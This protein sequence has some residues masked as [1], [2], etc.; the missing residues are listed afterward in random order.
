MRA[1]GSYDPRQY[2]EADPSL[3]RVLDALASDRFCPSEPG[4][5]RWLPETLLNRDEYFVIADFSSYVA[6]KRRIAEEYLQPARWTRKAILNVARVSC[7]SSDRT[8]R[9]YARDIWGLKPA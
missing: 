6:M 9:E 3:R 1:V 4:S 5:F 2:Y 7:F 8:V